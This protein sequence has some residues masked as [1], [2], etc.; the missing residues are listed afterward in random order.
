MEMTLKLGS[1]FYS[2]F[3]CVILIASINAPSSGQTMPNSTMPELLDE[4]IVV[5]GLNFRGVEG[6]KEI[7]T[8]N[9]AQ[10]MFAITIQN[11]TYLI[12]DKAN[13]HIVMQANDDPL[14]ERLYDLNFELPYALQPNQTIKM[15]LSESNDDDII[16]NLENLASKWDGHTI[17]FR[18]PDLTFANGIRYIDG[19]KVKQKSLSPHEGKNKR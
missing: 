4:A 13:C 16:K 12:I 5:T 3:F 14:S 2:L 17:F 7:R 11:N 10:P 15:Y 8:T 9:S 1:K 19:A 6:I 18:I